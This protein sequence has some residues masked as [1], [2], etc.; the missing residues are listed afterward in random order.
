MVYLDYASATPV[1]KA[2]LDTFIKANNDFF[3]NPNSIH[4]LGKEAK[5]QLDNASKRIAER[6]G[7]KENELIYTSGAT[8]TNNLVIK[9]IA[10]RYKNFGKHILL[11]SLEHQSLI[12]PA[13]SLEREG[14]E[15]ELIPLDKNG[16]VDL[17]ELKDTIRDDTILVSVTSVDS[18]LG[19]IQP[20]NEIGELLKEYKHCIFH[21]DASQAIGKIPINFSNVDLVTIA[22]HKF[23]GLNGT[24]LLIKKEHVELIPLIE[25]GRSTTPYRSGTPVLPAILALDKALELAIN[26]QEK[27]TKIVEKYNEMIISK[28]KT[29]PEVHINS[30]KYS[31]NYII[32]FSIKNINSTDFVDYM[33][34]NN[35]CLSAKTSCC[36]VDTPSKLVYALTKSKDLSTTSVRI[37]LSHL[38]TEKEISEFLK[39]FDN[40]YKEKINGKI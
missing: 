27:R 16:R 32:N 11:S 14:F 29:Y 3:A 21:T 2:V 25:G 40:F 22:P 6:L 10:R 1:D 5:N 18:E 8:E 34:K 23:Y 35:I 28:L 9:G 20:I 30:N 15:V 26:S 31:V 38:T 17:E 13:T 39:I 24:G 4:V 33:S 12:A 36:P 37:S 19:I 7:V